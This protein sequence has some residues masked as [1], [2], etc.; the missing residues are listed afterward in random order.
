LSF[1]AQRTGPPKMAV[2]T[3]VHVA[4]NRNN[5]FENYLK[6]DFVP[7]MRQAGVNYLVSQTIFGGNG[8]EY[9]A[10]TMRDS[11]A[12]LDK[13]PVHVQ[14]LGQEGAQKL[15]QKMPAGAV[16]NLE[17]SIARFVPELSIMPPAP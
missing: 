8:N 10:L 2:V 12:D 5:D 13:G 17:R 6:N 7:V 1:S 3:F 4:P 14:V 11:F 9:I 15:M 16:M